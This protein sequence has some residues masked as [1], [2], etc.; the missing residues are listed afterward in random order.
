MPAM[1]TD[2][3]MQAALDLVGW[4][5]IPADSAIYH[6]GTRI[7][8]VLLGIDID[9]D[10]VF[11]ARQLGYHAVIAQQ[12]CGDSGPFW[13]AFA[14]HSDLLADVGVPR[15]EAEAA[16]QPALNILRMQALRE[17]M[18]RVPSVARLLDQPCLNIQSPLDELGRRLLQTTI[19]T[20]LATKPMAMVADIHDALMTLPAFAAA[21]TEMLAP[22]HGWDVLAGRVVVIHGAYASPDYEIVKTY[23]AHGIDTICCAD[24]AAEDIAYLAEEDSAGNVLL[25]GRSA[26]I[27][28]GVLPYVAHLRARGIEVTTCAG[29]LGDEITG[30]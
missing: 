13:E 21:K 17:N 20:L 25:L 3:L 19:D 27:S 2:Q 4:Q 30:V 9:P 18:D 14:R 5:A 15:A 7:G 24:M 22:L 6:P 23:L 8:H 26:T 28:A 11:M 12:R 29:V 10:Q 1:N 16:V